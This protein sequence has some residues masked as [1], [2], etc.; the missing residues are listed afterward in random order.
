MTETNGFDTLAVQNAR[1]AAYALRECLIAWQTLE[2][3]ECDGYPED[4]R[5]EARKLDPDMYDGFARL[6]GD[7]SYAAMME[8]EHRA[9]YCAA[10]TLTNDPERSDDLRA[11]FER[12][13]DFGAFASEFLVVAIHVDEGR[14]EDLY[15]Y[16]E[17]AVDLIEQAAVGLEALDEYE[18]VVALANGTHEDQ[19]E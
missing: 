17:T 12:I 6:T 7:E 15:E 9:S 13:G 14:A 3:G 1:M 11:L 5:S 2:A 19:S 16:R 18:H 10:D 8:D 4:V